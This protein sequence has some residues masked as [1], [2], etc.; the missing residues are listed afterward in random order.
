MNREFSAFGRDE[1][2]CTDVTEFEYRVRK[3]SYLSAIIDLYDYSIISYRIGK[4][5]NNG[6]VFQ[7]LIPAITQ[8]PSGL[9][10]MI[11]SDYGYQYT[12][13]G[14]KR[15]IEDANLTHSMSRVGRT[16]QSRAFR[17]L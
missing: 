4:S 3:N 11:H 2:W 8:L 12:S 6:L 14:F 1:K 17:V 13:G 16:M 9:V 15:M 5:N 7:T 10:P